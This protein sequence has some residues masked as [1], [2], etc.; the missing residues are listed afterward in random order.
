MTAAPDDMLFHQ[1]DAQQQQQQQQRQPGSPVVDVHS[2]HSAEAPSAGARQSSAT[3]N[4]PDLD[5]DDELLELAQED[6]N[7][8]QAGRDI[9]GNAAGSQEYLDN[10]DE[11]MLALAAEFG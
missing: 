7:D 10:E 3:V 4:Q 1:G 11:E 9:D 8:M 2:R 5:E 6:D